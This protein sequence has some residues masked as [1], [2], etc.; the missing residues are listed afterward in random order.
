MISLVENQC[1]TYIPA[2][3]QIIDV[4]PQEFHVDNFQNIKDPIGYN[5]V[6]VGANFHII[7]GDKNAIRNIN[8][9]VEK[10]D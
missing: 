3:D 10:A 9:A 8:R 4:I 7:T 5:G 6:K 1:K 2:G